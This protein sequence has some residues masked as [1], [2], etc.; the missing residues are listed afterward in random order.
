M[1]MDIFVNKLIFI[2]KGWNHCRKI[3]RE[4]CCFGND[5][6][7]NYFELVV[8]AVEAIQIDQILIF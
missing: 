2:R 4:M 5:I 8:V 6:V 1:M 7:R 3:I